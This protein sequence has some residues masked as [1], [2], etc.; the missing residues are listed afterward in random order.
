MASMDEWLL[1][2]TEMSLGMFHPDYY[3]S[4][5]SESNVLPLSW[6]SFCADMN[7]LSG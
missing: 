1:S 6:T 3:R 4:L 7:V 5:N 2:L